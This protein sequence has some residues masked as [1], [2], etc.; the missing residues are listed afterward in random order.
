MHYARVRSS[1][2]EQTDIYLPFWA[3]TS[4]GRENWRGERKF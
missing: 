1:K 4:E 3:V 2:E